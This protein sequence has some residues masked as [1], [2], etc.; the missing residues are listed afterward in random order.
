MSLILL[1]HT[2]PKVATGTCYGQTDLD[3]CDNF[4]FE[5]GRIISELPEVDLLVTSPLRR[6]R[7][8][9]EAIA[10]HR[11]LLAQID[12]RVQEIDFG[13]WEGVPWSEIPRAEIDA[14]ADCFMHARPHG[15]ESVAMLHCRIQGALAH[16]QNNGLRTLIVTHA[17]VIKAALAQGRMAADFATT[18]DFG[19]FVAL[20]PAQ[21]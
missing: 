12:T 8:L 7:V 13:T 21:A 17:G 6:C 10:A 1:R 15:G 20:P 18:V 9:A 3:V 4:N 11:G 19:C 2:Q 16:Y 14:W 5:V